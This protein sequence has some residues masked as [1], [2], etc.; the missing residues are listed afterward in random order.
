MKENRTLYSL[1]GAAILVVAACCATA[2]AAPVEAPAGVIN[3]SSIAD[4]VYPANVA[5]TP[6]AMQFMPDGT[7]FLRMSDG[8]KKITR[9]DI[10]T[11][12]EVETVFDASHTREN[13]VASVD[14]FTISPGGTKLLLRT[15]TTPVYR[16][17]VK[18]AYYVFEIK[19]NILRPLSKQH[20]LQ[21]APLFS[22]DDRMV[23]FVAENNI[24][25]KKTD[26]DTEV[27]VTED[28]EINK[29]INGIPDWT[30]EEEF[31]TGS[32]MAWAPD[33]TSLC[34]LRYDESRVPMFTFTDYA[35]WCH[36]RQEYAL[37]PGQFSYKY[38]VAGEP[39]SIVSVHTYDVDTRK[40]KEVAL[41][42]ANIEYIPRL[43]FGGDSADRL[44]IVTLDRAQSRM[45]VYMANPKSTVAKS[46]L[47]EQAKAW[48]NPS[49]YEDIKFENDGFTV[50][51]ERTGWNAL[52]K[53]SYAGQE[54][55]RISSPDD[56]EVTAYYGTDALGNAYYQAV[57][58]GDGAAK[59]LN[60]VVRRIDRT[61][62]KVENLTPDSGWG[63]AQFAPGMSF[64]ITNYSTSDT[65][66]VYTLFNGKGKQ[67]RV[68]E[69]NAA[70]AARYTQAPRREFFTMQSDGTTLNGYMVKPAN[71]DSSRRYP[72]IMWQYSGPGSQEVVN[73][74]KMDWDVYAATQGF[75][76]VCVDGRGTGARGEAFRDV[77]Y[78]RLG[79]YE[80]IDQIA[81]A[82][83]V[84][85]LPYADGDRIGLS[86]WSYGGYET[87]MGVTSTDSPWKAAVAIAP[88]T[89]WRY[90][91]TVY[92]E[93]YML[94][95]Q[96]NADGY[97]ESAPVDRASRLACRLLI[98][99]GTADDNV[100]L[101]NTMEFAGALQA[102]DRYC[103]MLLF[104]A[105]NHSIHGCDARA[106]VYGRMI[107]YFR[108]NL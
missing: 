1:A 103:D 17:S 42:D 6:G 91:D 54:L 66:P 4:Y 31:A 80:T 76:V 70:Y 79:Y 60:R 32:S 48:L 64:Y 5:A 30:Y 86:G 10:A 105:M 11:G 67:V 51:S 39:N 90:Y 88:V 68:L 15:S 63:S 62:K 12:K 35:G 16:R 53:Y 56:G 14:A 50:M 82:R 106:L 104:P 94:T 34:Y 75:L 99:H 98:I 71:F 18:A 61:G 23:A 83:Y 52:Y 20:A 38:P 3:V 85:S 93:R 13:S 49:T 97:A 108:D 24:Y 95:P 59:A 19:R 55:R 74:W 81:A 84:A 33:N 26:Y 25:I 43:E 89:S 87:L 40:T 102:A 47:V 65:P 107:Q 29:I 100:H 2:E 46:L 92:A 41:P 69:D 45:E 57:P 96:E 36:P 78:K 9:C 7:T 101:S 28:G 73:R 77:V 8:G 22:P 72:V 27:A 37:Y 21:Q 58:G 44:M